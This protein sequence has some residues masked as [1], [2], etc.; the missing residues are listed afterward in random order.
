MQLEFKHEK[1]LKCPLAEKDE[2][3]QFFC[4]SEQCVYDSRKSDGVYF[5]DAIEKLYKQYIDSKKE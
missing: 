1:C 4:I 2:I 5:L 3:G